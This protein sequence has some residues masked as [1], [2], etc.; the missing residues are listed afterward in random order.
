MQ[1]FSGISHQ[2]V[3]KAILEMKYTHILCMVSVIAAN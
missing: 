1:Y 2:Y 3:V